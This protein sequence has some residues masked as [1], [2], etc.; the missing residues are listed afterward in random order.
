MAVS[1]GLGRP[2]G[3]PGVAARGGSSKQ[4]QKTIGNVKITLICGFITILVLRGT[5]GVNLLSFS[6][7]GSTS[8]DAAAADA[9]QVAEDIDRLLREIRSDAADEDDN[10]D[11]SPDNST[12]TTLNGAA[13]ESTTTIKN[14]TLGPKITRWNAK[15]RQWQARHPGF[16]ARDA[17]GKPRILL[18][19]GSSPGP[20]DDP[21]GDHFLL[22]STKNKID[23]CRIH[24]IELVHSMAHLDRELSGYWSKLPLLRRLMLSHP[25]TEWVWWMDSDALFTDMAF[26]LPLARYD[27]SNLVIHGYHDLLHKQRSWVALNTGSF[28][29]RNCQW[30]LELLDAWAPMGPKGQV[31]EAA[32]KVLTASL[33]GRPAFEADDQSALIHLLLADKQRWMDKVYVEDKFYLHGFWAGLVDRY[34]EMMEK[35]HPGLGDERWPF[36]THFVGCKPCGSY[37]DYP[38]D[39]CLAAMERAFNFADNQVLRIYGFRHRSL[40]SPKVKPVPVNRTATPFDALD[41]GP[42][43]KTWL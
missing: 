29:L 7:A 28:L 20:C 21:A 10:I 18:V 19:T 38:K 4:M 14:Y 3:R 25:E 16:P 24:G 41:M 23:Y 8:G 26:E 43:V 13:T 32:G 1:G 15:R 17:R 12:T 9:A 31:R 11:L 2:A 42:K 5:V 34:E 27:G 37:G 35:H 33:T 30:S 6:G 22:K 40:A 36:V 39:V